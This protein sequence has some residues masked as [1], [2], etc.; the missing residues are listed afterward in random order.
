MPRAYSDDLRS[1]LLKAYGAGRGSLEELAQ[2][3]GVSY[4]YSKKI[5]RQQLES[6]QAERPRQQRHGPTGQLSA[7]IKQ[8]LHTA[9]AR[10]PD[11]TL[12]ELRQRLRTSHQV[13]ISCSRL[14]YW[15]RSLGLRHKKNAARPGAG[16]R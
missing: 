5:R 12:A 2:Q 15:L 14:W 8:Y 13:E 7:E 11:V 10:Q 6:G 4:G 3:F 1:K 9:V 16:Q